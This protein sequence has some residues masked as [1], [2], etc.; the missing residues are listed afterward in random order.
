MKTLTPRQIGEKFNKDAKFINEIF[1]DLDFISRDKNGFKLT[2]KGEN[3]GGEQKNYMGKFYV[4]WDEKILSNKL[5]LKLINSDE[6]PEQNSDEND[7]RK[8]FEAQYRTKSGHFVRSRAEVI[9]ADW[10]FNELVVFAYEKRVPIMDEMYCDFYLPCENSEIS[11]I[12]ST[13]PPISCALT[14]NIA[15]CFL[16]D[17][18]KICANFSKST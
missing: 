11:D 7:F 5:F 2:K 13:L 9:I 6:T 4:A 15:P 8:K 14:S 1:M 10:L 12:L 17:A 18:L 3:F 16:S